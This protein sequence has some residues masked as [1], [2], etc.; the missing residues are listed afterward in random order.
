MILRREGNGCA[1]ASSSKRAEH[2]L[3]RMLAD[4]ARDF[5][6]RLALTEAQT[7]ELA[8]AVDIYMAVYAPE[9]SAAG[10]HDEP[11]VAM[12]A[13]RALA[14]LGQGEVARRLLVYG[15]GLVSPALWEVSRGE[16]MWVLDLKRLTVSSMAPLEITLFRCLEKVITAS[17]DLWDAS[18][19]EG[20]LGLRHVCAT[21]AGL[22][23]C[24]QGSKA[25]RCLVT[26]LRD[27]ALA[28]LGETGA[29]RGWLRVPDV[30]C[31]DS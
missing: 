14:D 8:R 19:G 22:L 30:I 28:Q 29:R 10:R 26:E 15:T 11:F 1:T 3:P 6:G 18:R 20:M 17:A 25:V 4:L 7:T 13:S 2:L 31:L 27:A 23:N 16:A 5:G 24:R 12:L 9:R 21:A